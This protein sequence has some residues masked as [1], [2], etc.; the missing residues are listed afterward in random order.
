MVRR[1]AEI[2]T[3]IARS[4]GDLWARDASG[5]ISLPILVEQNAPSPQGQSEAQ[6]TV[7]P[8][9]LEKRS[10]VSR[11]FKNL[12]HKIKSGFQSFGRK[13]KSGFQ[14]VGHWLKD[15]WQTVLQ[16]GETVASK[17]PIER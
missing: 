11:W 17:I 1:E 7:G 16:V 15:N 2:F 8:R 4:D 13:L 6:G 3:A 10:K 5:G 14:K 9:S 12:G